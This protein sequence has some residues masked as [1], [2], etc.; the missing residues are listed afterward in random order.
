MTTT[1]SLLH[2]HPSLV[3]FWDFQEAAG[4]RR[5][6]K[7]PNAIEL[8]EMSGT[9][10]R[11][12]EGIFGPYSASL[13]EGDWFSVPR[14]EA[15]ALNI[16][17]RNA[18]VTVAAWVKR[19][20]TARSH[21]EFIAG[22]WNETNEKRQYGLFL[23]LAIWDSG[24][25]VC[26]HVSSIGG[27]TPGY[28]YCMDASI[29]QSPVPLDRWQFVAFTYDGEYAR[30]YLNGK[31]DTRETFNPYSY[32]GG[33]YDGGEDGAD[34]TVGAVDRSGEIGNYYAGRIGGLAVF[35]QALSEQEIA[36]MA[37]GIKVS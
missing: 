18:E 17:G 23:N 19:S 9:I 24:E 21:C 6:S 20:A 22:I 1:S 16:H 27:P 29:G 8:R 7:G 15:F 34:F 10:E 30:S 37:C 11:V 25:Q 26:G 31:L 4:E 32:R 36:Q 12:E 2:N 13:R 35:R 3:A 14:N 5:V 33:L 28:R